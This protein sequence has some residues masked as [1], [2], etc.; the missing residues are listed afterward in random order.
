MYYG[1]G[2]GSS[3]GSYKVTFNAS[4]TDGSNYITKKPKC[5]K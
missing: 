1:I 2:K 4:N 5:Y 3:Q